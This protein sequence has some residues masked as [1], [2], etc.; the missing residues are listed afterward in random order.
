MESSDLN[1]KNENIKLEEYP[2]WVNEPCPQCGAN[3][4]TEEDFAFAQMMI[5]LTKEVNQI[6]PPREVRED[7][8][9][10]KVTLDLDGSGIPKVKS[11]SILNS[12]DL[13]KE[14]K[15]WI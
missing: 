7:S 11:V 12:E 1:D 6:I 2:E 14:G 3:L 4:L 13:K 9:A 8:I 15:S 5:K 10:Q